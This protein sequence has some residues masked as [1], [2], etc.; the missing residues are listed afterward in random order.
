M[1]SFDSDASPDDEESDTQQTFNLK[2]KLSSQ[3]SI[4]VIKP[5]K[6]I[7]LH[8][9]NKYNEEV[10][11]AESESDS[12]EEVHERKFFDPLPFNCEIESKNE[13]FY[14]D[15]SKDILEVRSFN[16]KK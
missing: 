14:L 3:S 4:F 9:L 10:P 2:S 12:D 6:Q 8:A 13:Y 16:R 11:E 15:N 1:Q 5:F 7:N